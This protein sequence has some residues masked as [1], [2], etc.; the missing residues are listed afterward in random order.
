MIPIMQ[1]SDYLERN[2]IRS[3]QKREDI[4]HNDL[5]NLITLQ[6]VYFMKCI[7]THGN[8]KNINTCNDLHKEIKYIHDTLMRC[9]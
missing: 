1:L 3:E 6:K 8:K 4:Q 5:S 9:N 2:R 7:D